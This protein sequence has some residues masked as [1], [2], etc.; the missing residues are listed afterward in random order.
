MAKQE[1]CAI[2]RFSRVVA[3][4]LECRALPPVS[5]AGWPVVPGAGWCAQFL[6]KED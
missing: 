3:K 4:K 2:C 5:D 6:P 1:K